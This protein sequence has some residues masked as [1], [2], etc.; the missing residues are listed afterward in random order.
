[1]SHFLSI[2]LVA[3]ST[4][5]NSVSQAQPNWSVTA[6]DYEY[7]MT[8][9]TAA[10]F[11]CTQSVDTNDLV[12]AFI[13]GE[14]RGIQKLNTVFNG[15]NLA[16]M[17]IYDNAFNGSEV[18]FRMYDAS[19]DS[20]FDATQSIEFVENGNTGNSDNPFLLSTDCATGLFQFDNNRVEQI[21][22]YP[23]PASSIFTIKTESKIDQW[24][25]Y[26]LSGKLVYSK[27]EV[28]SN[29]IDVSILAPQLYMLVCFLDGSIATSKILVLR[30]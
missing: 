17:I 30:N 11:Q 22:V 12:A 23:N 27:N 5:L 1:M 4:L 14:V 2:L 29:D 10:V 13:N 8:I 3:G 19:L 7:S 24:R 20:V 15:S 21:S 16:F 9:T 25:I 18:T 6:S 26:D 28:S